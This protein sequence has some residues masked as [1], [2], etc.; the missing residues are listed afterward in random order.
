MS[1]TAL[2]LIECYASCAETHISPKAASVIFMAET[3]T[4][5]LGGF[6]LPTLR[7]SI[8]HN[9]CPV[10]TLQPCRGSQVG[11]A[12]DSQIQCHNPP[13]LRHRRWSGCHRQRRAAHKRDRWF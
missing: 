2:G 6:R 10:S 9:I 4:A 12:V 13:F 5:L 8:S 3:S 7:D 11:K 1:D